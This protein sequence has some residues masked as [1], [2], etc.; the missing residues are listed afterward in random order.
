MTAYANV[1]K[2]FFLTRDQCHVIRALIF[3]GRRDI[4]ADNTVTLIT[5]AV[6]AYGSIAGTYS[7]CSGYKSMDFVNINSEVAGYQCLPSSPPPSF[8]LPSFPSVAFRLSLCIHICLRCSV[9]LSLSPS[10]IYLSTLSPLVLL[11]YSVP[12]VFF[13]AALPPT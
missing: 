7:Y 2:R 8:L 9:S 11:L 1:T 4:G 13:A 3:R 10:L 6:P 12:S 5:I